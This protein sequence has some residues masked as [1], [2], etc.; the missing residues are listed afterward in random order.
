MLAGTG[1]DQVNL[2]VVATSERGLAGEFNTNIVSAARKH[3]DA[4]IAQG[5]KVKFYI[6]G[7]KGRVMRRF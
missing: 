6:A 5:K 3:A 4:L 1:K 2:I 7:K